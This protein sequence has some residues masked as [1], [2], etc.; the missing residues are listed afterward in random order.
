LTNRKKDKFFKKHEKENKDSNVAVYELYPKF[1][2]EFNV[3]KGKRCISNIE[4]NDRISLLKKVLTLSGQT[5]KEI[6]GLPKEK[7][8][9][10]ISKE[11]FI[12]IPGVP[13]K[14]KD[15][16]KIDVFRFSD[17]GRLIGYIEDEI[18]YVVWVD[19]KYEMYKH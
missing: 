1:S 9:E 8:F 5:W 11:S 19:T 7:G 10:K 18:F 16:E 4:K 3:D 12:A 15:I 2:F 14:F 17:K 13:H 6:S